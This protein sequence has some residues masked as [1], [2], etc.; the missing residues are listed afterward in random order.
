MGAHFMSPRS[1]WKWLYN[2]HRLQGL[3]SL[4]YSVKKNSTLLKFRNANIPSVLQQQ[5]S[6]AAC[7]NTYTAIRSLSDSVPLWSG[8]SYR[9]FVYIGN[10][11]FCFTADCKRYNR[12]DKCRFFR[13]PSNSNEFK[14]WEHLNR[15][16]SLIDTNLI[17][18]VYKWAS[19]LNGRIPQGSLW[20]PSLTWI[21]SR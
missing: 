16:K 11:G 20:R 3:L 10:D 8:S 15:L 1:A 19:P 17:A 5:E 13:F 2:T 6:H 4:S 12:K 14:K 18:I 9:A 7:S 21:N